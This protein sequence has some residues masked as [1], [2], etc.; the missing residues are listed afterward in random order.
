M[1]IKLSAQNIALASLA[2]ITFTSWLGLG[3][4]M[5]SKAENETLT[6]VQWVLLIQGSIAYSGFI[7]ILINDIEK[8]KKPDNLVDESEDGRWS[9]IDDLQEPTRIV[10]VTGF[11]ES[12]T[13]AAERTVQGVNTIDERLIRLARVN[14]TLLE[15]PR[16]SK[17]KVEQTPF[18][19]FFCCSRCKFIGEYRGSC[20]VVPFGCGTGDRSDECREFEAKD[21]GIQGVEIDRPESEIVRVAMEALNNSSLWQE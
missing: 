4:S 17:A 5:R 8:E 7:G 18:R 13:S 21:D 3:L 9:S 10:L 19:P 12:L 11:D 16:G 14:T 6:P 2:A 20:A 1:K 15:E